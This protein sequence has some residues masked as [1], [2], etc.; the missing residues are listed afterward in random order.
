MFFNSIEYLLFLP[1]VFAV[2]WGI[3]AKKTWPR[4]VFLILA[5]CVFYGWWDI[6]F[7]VLLLGS[8]TTDF[9][10]GILISRQKTNKRRK[11]FLILSIVFNIGLLGYFKYYN[12]FAENFVEAFTF[13]GKKADIRFLKV[14]LPVGISFY[15]FQSLSYTIMIYRGTMKATRNIIQY[16]AF[17]SFFPQLVA[18][19]I[20]RASRLLPQFEK[21]KRFDYAMAVGGMR[22]ILYGL[23]KKV[24]IADNCASYANEIFDKYPQYSGL[25]LF[26]GSVYF[27]IQ[28][29]CDFS[30]YSDIAIGSA[31][32]FGFQ[33]MNNFNFPYFSR[34]M[35]EFWRKWHISLTSWFR[36]YVYIPLGGSKGSKT[37]IIRNVVIVFLVSGFWHGAN[38]TFIFWG[39]INALYFIPLL[40]SGK[41]RNHVEVIAIER[42]LP[43]WK[44]LLQM[45]STFILC[46]LA[47]VF[48]RSPGI[49]SAFQ[50]LKCMFTKP[51]FSVDELSLF[52]GLLPVLIFMTIEWMNRRGYEHGVFADR[53]GMPRY[54][55]LIVETILILLIID[56]S[57]STDHSQFIYFQF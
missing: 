48:F 5:A 33:L 40:L 30:G 41:N 16:I 50:Y 47:W 15:T 19:P 53:P 52:K 26:A 24:V 9:F 39:L 43:S 2:Y 29:Y 55:L 37:M 8:A 38:W 12:F 36:D 6:R 49:G 57:V 14:I 18:G 22:L 17:V 10:I 28:I 11:Y 35:A 1:L 46:C 32:L 13:F 56:F 4:N 54:A 42:N 25:T 45:V 7:L 34:N 27:A 31:R 20:E 44:E 23:F 51:Y 21:P 3:P